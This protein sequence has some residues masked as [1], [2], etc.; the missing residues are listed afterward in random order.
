LIDVDESQAEWT[1][2]EAVDPFGRDFLSDEP[3]QDPLA[4]A[5]Q[6]EVM[7]EV[8]ASG[9]H[10]AAANG[11]PGHVR[12]VTQA[13]SVATAYFEDTLSVAP[14]EVLS[15]GSTSAVELEAMLAEA[16]FAAITSGFG[17]AET[18]MRVREMVDSGVLVAQAVSAQV[19]KGWLSAVRGAL[20][21]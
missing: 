4:A 2:Q 7:A 14:Q 9:Q 6:A 15:A 11:I 8:R 18:Q 19:P 13:I 21:S 20:R 12:E 3:I 1:M 16:E 10:R 5:I 17:G